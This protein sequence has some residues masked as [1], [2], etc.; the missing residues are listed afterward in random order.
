LFVYCGGLEGYIQFLGSALTVNKE[1]F[2]L[3]V[4]VKYEKIARSISSTDL[5]V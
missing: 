3:A 4:L 2:L 1:T 5:I